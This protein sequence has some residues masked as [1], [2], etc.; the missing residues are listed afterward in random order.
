MSD[1]NIP[2]MLRQAADNLTRRPYSKAFFTGLASGSRPSAE[3]IVPLILDFVDARSVVDVGCGVGTWLSVFRDHGVGDVLGVD[4]DYVPRA[5]LEIPSEQFHAADLS[6]PLSVGRRFDLAVSLE[7]AEHLPP[8]S[9]EQF[10]ATL[11][12]LSDLVLFSAAIPRQRGSEHVN[13][14]WQSW[15]AERFAG[16]GF[17]PIDCV[18][19]R[20]WSNPSV[21]WWY[22]QNVILYASRDQLAARPRLQREYELM[23]TG[24]LS[25]VHPARYVKWRKRLRDILLS[26]VP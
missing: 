8:A 20:I 17:V 12:G 6:E 22:A 2:S 23:G 16:H 18:R 26:D 25:I 14:R 5:Q 24:Q 19:R 7:V 3:A 15:W 9:S 4:G 11:V 13:E 21:E 1:A 10:V